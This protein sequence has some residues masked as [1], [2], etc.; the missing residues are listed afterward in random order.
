MSDK[1]NKCYANFV[2]SDCATMIEDTFYYSTIKEALTHS[3]TCPVCG[4][5]GVQTSAPES[6]KDVVLG[7]LVKGYHVA[8]I[9]ESTL[10]IVIK[11]RFE[12]PNIEKDLPYEFTLDRTESMGDIIINERLK[13]NDLK[14]INED[15]YRDEAI[16]NLLRWVGTLD[17][18]SQNQNRQIYY[19]KDETAS[20]DEVTSEEVSNIAKGYAPYSPAS[21]YP[22]KNGYACK[23]TWEEI[24]DMYDS[25]PNEEKEK[26][27]TL[28]DYVD[29]LFNMEDYND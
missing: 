15:N 8:V 11:G 18:V 10:C 17:V 12:S 14:D 22:I 29:T 7:L 1:R 23:Y 20:K 4:K 2:C 28:E 26:F 19:I 6:M 25:L 27:N 21:P 16:H 5:K 24:N 9:N 3:I 13:A